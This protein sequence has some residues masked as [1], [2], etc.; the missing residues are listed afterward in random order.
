[1]SLTTPF[2]LSIVSIHSHNTVA[3]LWLEIMTTRGEI[4]IAAEHA[5][6][7][8]ILKPKSIIVYREPSGAESSLPINSGMFYMN[9]NRGL[10]LIKE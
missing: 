10:L 8:A 2:E 5:P 7:V 1:M 6:F 3:V 4:V 9:G